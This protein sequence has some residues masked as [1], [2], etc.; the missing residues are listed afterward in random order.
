L[1]VLQSNVSK[2]PIWIVWMKMTK[3]TSECLQCY[4]S[5]E[6]LR[7]LN[8]PILQRNLFFHFGENFE[9]CIFGRWFLC[10]L[11]RLVLAIFLFVFRFLARC[12]LLYISGALGAPY[13]FNK[14]NLLLIKKKIETWSLK[15]IWLLYITQHSG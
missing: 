8:K 5:K 7:N 12:F 13:V 11:C 9:L 2:E 1:I 6:Q 10:P 14:T 15:W 4:K 3:I